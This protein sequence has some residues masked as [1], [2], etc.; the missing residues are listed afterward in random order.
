MHQDKALK[1]DR[2]IPASNDRLYGELI[3]A[4][5]A[6]LQL[7]KNHPNVVGISTGTKYVKSTATD[8]HASI[9]FY[10][11]EKGLPKRHRG[12]TLP[13]F[14]YGRFKNGKINR[15]LKFTTDLIKVGRVRMVCGAGSPISGSIGLTRQD[16]TMTFIFKNKAKTDKNSYVVSC[17]HVIGDIDGQSDLPVIIESECS[18]GITPFGKIT[19]SS[20]QDHK[21]IEYDVAI[22]QINSKCLPLPDLK[23][24]GT[25]IIIRSLMPKDQIIPSLP[26]SCMLPVSNAKSGVVGSYGGVVKIEYGKRTYKV[27]NAWMVKVDSRVREGDSGGLIYDNNVAIGI[28]FGAS[29]S[30]GGWAWFHPLIDAFEYVCENVDMELK[31]FNS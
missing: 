8:N 14:V 15:K 21:L 7:Y 1:R 17:A 13:R 27:E 19:F 26:V 31:C 11:K 9:Q 23:I 20:V 6:A 28:V 18:P 25:D 5:R 30:G 4:K 12:K 2:R 22:A 3:R 10:V 16:G 29:K 24:E